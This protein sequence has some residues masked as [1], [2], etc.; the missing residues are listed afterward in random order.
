MKRPW[1]ASNPYHFPED[2][3]PAIP[4]SN[5]RG[6]WEIL[7]AYLLRDCNISVAIWAPKISFALGLT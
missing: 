2:G 3:A 6:G 1:R 4:L 7:Y 5:I